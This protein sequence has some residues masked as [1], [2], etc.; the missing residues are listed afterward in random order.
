MYFP[1]MF[2]SPALIG[3]EIYPQLCTVERNENIALDFLDVFESSFSSSLI[4]LM[5][6]NSV[7]K[8]YEM[9]FTVET[10]TL[11]SALFVLRLI[12]KE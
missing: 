10:T 7:S 4:T 5:Y 2:L 11:T 6:F 3:N 8:I 1:V 9:L 12:M